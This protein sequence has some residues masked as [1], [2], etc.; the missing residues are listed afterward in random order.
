MLHTLWAGTGAGAC[1]LSSHAGDPTI[2]FVSRW[3]VGR[4]CFRHTWWRT[5]CRVWRRE[6]PHRQRATQWCIRL[7]F[8]RNFAPVGSWVWIVY[9]PVKHGVRRWSQALEVIPRTLAEN[10]LGGAEG[11]EV[12]SRLW[13][14]HEQEGGEA[15]GVDVEV[16]FNLIAHVHV[17]INVLRRPSPMAHSTHS[18]TR[19]STL[20][21]PSPGRSDWPLRQP[22]RF[23]AWTASS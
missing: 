22:S 19:S 13:A 2:F 11:N 17:L 3:T 21:L 14:K 10:A 4:K 12:V 16:S 20:S 5:R 15:W 9:V 6:R 23:S 18:S 7:I 8:R 1:L